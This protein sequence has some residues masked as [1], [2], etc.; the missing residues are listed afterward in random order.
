MDY[1][2]LCFA[3]ALL[4]A[5]ELFGR[6]CKVTGDRALP[7]CYKTSFDA[8]RLFFTNNFQFEFCFV[9]YLFMFC[10]CF[11]SVLSL[12]SLFFFATNKEK[13]LSMF[14]YSGLNK[15]WPKLSSA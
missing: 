10:L 14:K 2:N 11:V 1:V 5:Y 6:N 15:L 7:V 13:T 4:K 8:I 12:F 9:F 3:I